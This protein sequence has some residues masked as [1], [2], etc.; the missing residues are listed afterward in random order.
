[1]RISKSSLAACAF[2]A[3]TQGWTPAVNAE[4]DAL[5]LGRELFTETA[6]P[7]CAVCH[8]LADANSDGA[9]G[10]DLDELKPDQNR[11]TAAVKGGMGTMPA[12]E[13]LSDDEVA[14][15]AAYVSTATA[16]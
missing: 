15:L 11:V 13:T 9:I 2:V 5:K 8:T 3:L 12:Y 6:N 14:A 4:D 7:P 1:M 16:K 10:P